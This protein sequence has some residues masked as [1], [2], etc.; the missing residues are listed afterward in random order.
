VRRTL[1][2]ATAPVGRGQVLLEALAVHER[3]ILGG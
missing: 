1:N 2:A 3:S